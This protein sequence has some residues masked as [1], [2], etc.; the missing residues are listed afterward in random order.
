VR[1]AGGRGGIRA[2]DRG[3]RGAVIPA[4]AKIARAV[5]E[6]NA[7]SGRKRSADLQT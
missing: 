6:M 2:L 3:A 1:E 7:A 5:A 4:P